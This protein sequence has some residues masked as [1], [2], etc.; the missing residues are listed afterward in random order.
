MRQT[1]WIQRCVT[2]IRRWRWPSLAV[3]AAVTAVAAYFATQV[4]LDTSLETRFLEDDVT[5]M[6][7]KE[8]R[9]SFGEDEFVVLSL[10]ADNVFTPRI[11]SEL[12]R[13]TKMAAEVPLVEG[14]MSLTNVEV[15]RGL[16]RG[17]MH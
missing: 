17:T 6:A 10:E 7:Y 11:L 16:W 15:M 13:L 3:I 12:E 14:V 4:E 2:L 1:G 8:F 9:R 5:L